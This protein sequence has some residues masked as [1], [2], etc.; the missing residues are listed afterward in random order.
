MGR[1]ADSPEVMLLIKKEQS[2]NVVGVGELWMHPRISERSQTQKV[3]TAGLC[4][5]KVST[6]GEFMERSLSGVGGREGGVAT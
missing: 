2:A 5:H 6:T 1:K 4:L 3:C